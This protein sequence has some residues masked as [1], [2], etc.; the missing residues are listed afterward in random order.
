MA[1]LYLPTPAEECAPAPAFAEQDLLIV[2]SFGSP[3]AADYGNHVAN[4][5]AKTIDL[6][7][8]AE[9]ASLRAQLASTSASAC[10]LF[11]NPCWTESAREALDTLIPS[12]RSARHIVV[13]SSFRIHLRDQQAA[14]AEADALDL[15]ERLPA[16]MVVFRP[17]HILSGSSRW[18]RDL[19]RF[20]FAHPLVPWRMRSCFVDGAELF[21]AIDQER[22]FA[23]A[24]QQPR[25]AG[26]RPLR[27]RVITLL[28]R[29]DT[30]KE[31]LWRHKATG[32]FSVCLTALCYVAALL[33]VGQIAAL[34]LA[35]LMRLRP[36]L[37]RWNLDM[38]CPQSFAELLALCNRY[39]IQ[40]VKIVGYNNGV[41]H[42]GN[43]YP[44]TT[45]V[46]TVHCNRIIRV[47]A[48]VIRA[49]CGATIRQARDFVA[50][51]NQELPVIPNYSYVCLGTA[52]FVP[53]HGSASDFTTVA[54]TITRALFY[55]PVRELVVFASSDD[56]AFRDTVYNMGS[57]LIVLRVWTHV[58]PCARYFVHHQ[59][60][61]NP[62]SEE[63]LGALRDAEATNV[64]IRQPKASHSTVIVSRYYRAADE[65]PEDLLEVPRDAIGR[66]WD[67]LEE[68]AVSSFLL[69]ALARTLIWHVELFFPAQDFAVFWKTHQALPLRKIQ[70]RHIRRD[71]LPHSPFREQDC[72]S[73]DMFMFRWHRARFET[74][75]KQT[76][77]VVR[78]NPGKHSR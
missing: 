34:V 25:Q 35:L 40:H 55:D 14:L 71:G 66:L 77:G 67:R 26:T 56:T 62:S 43:R 15:L 53:I 21:G 37:R 41:V 3:V 33:L 51:A 65:G 39:N 13:V 68:N 20:G 59:E 38:I 64:E 30:W 57:R 8:R 22:A 72:V 49:D 76:F 18:S 60:C 54:E 19:R 42:F 63:L 16:R 78:S 27:S 48:D 45:V 4:C 17:G 6:T 74:Y 32:P 70:L 7:D 5:R 9:L 44:G 47:A 50:P 29:N 2:A 36:P 69:H 10:V 28:G 11:L 46:S 31:Q 61:E 52:L 1:S 23:P 24:A 75:V 73:V 12:I 58:K